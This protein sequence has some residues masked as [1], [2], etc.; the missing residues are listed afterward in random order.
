MF[1]AQSFERWIVHFHSSQLIA[2]APRSKYPF[3]LLIWKS[4]ICTVWAMYTVIWYNQGLQRGIVLLK[5]RVYIY[6]C[7]KKKEK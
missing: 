1:V 7:V 4:Y 6:T 3:H 5:E 2:P